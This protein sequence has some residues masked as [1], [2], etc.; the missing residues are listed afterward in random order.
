MGCTGTNQ[1]ARHKD[2]TVQSVSSATYI[3]AMVESQH[4]EGTEQA[5]FN[6]IGVYILS[7]VHM[8]APLPLPPCGV[9]GEPSTV[10]LQ[11]RVRTDKIVYGR[12]S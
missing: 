4:K 6:Q 9:H 3:W 11:T 1:M 7:R 12:C 8:R 10:R 5:P 2:F